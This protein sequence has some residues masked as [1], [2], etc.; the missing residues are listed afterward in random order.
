MAKNNN[1]KEAEG[2]ITSDKTTESDTSGN[3]T[4]KNS[5]NKKIEQKEISNTQE[6]NISNE[7]SEHKETN[8]ESVKSE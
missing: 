8:N 1:L 2:S 3:D 4:S 5:V 7:L 6:T